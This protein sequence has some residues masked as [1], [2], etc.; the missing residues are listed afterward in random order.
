VL[1]PVLKKIVCKSRALFIRL[2]ATRAVARARESHNRPRVGERRAREGRRVTALAPGES[3]RYRLALARAGAPAR[4]RGGRE[5]G[6]SEA[7]HWRGES[8][9][10]SDMA[11]SDWSTCRDLIGPRVLA[12]ATSRF[13]PFGVQ[14]NRKKIA[15]NH[16]FHPNHKFLLIIMYF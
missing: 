7:R 2:V 6:E 10:E 14:K 5:G 11:R 15:K 1:L 12:V 4:A 9:G 8:A 16:K 3:R 13:L